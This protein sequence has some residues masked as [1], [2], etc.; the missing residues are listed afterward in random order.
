[1]VAEACDDVHPCA[2]VV[3]L[4]TGGSEFEPLDGGELPVEFGLINGAGGGYHFW[5]SA[6]TRGLCPIVWLGVD[7]QAEIHGEP[8]SIASASRHV[9]MVREPGSPGS[10]QLYW[11]VR[12][13]PPC[14][15]WPEDPEHG[16]SCGTFQ[17]RLG[18]LQDFE[19]TVT[20]TVED[21]D[22]RRGSDVRTLQPICCG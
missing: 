10:E 3:E 11:G 19:L 1:M 13:F 15:L 17:S 22:G 14:E 6:R 9:Q 16:A 18:Y 12:L 4:G 8:R 5:V 2:S 20:L 21:H 7:V